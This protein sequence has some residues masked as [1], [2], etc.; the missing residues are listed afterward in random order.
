MPPRCSMPSSRACRARHPTTTF[1]S[2][3][4]YGAAREHLVVEA[5]DSEL[6]VVGTSGCPVV[7][8]HPSVRRRSGPRATSAF[9][10]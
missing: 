7:V 8:V 3:L 2:D 1:E 5:K 9:G 10:G 6:L 4:L